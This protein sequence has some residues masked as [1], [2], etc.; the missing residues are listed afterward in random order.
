MI[1]GK[2][3]HL[4]DLTMLY[5]DVIFANNNLRQAIARGSADTRIKTNQTDFTL[6]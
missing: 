2:D 1:P 5:Q 4:N 3:F 6:L